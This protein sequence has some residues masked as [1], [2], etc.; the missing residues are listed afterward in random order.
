[1]MGQGEHLSNDKGPQASLLGTPSS[2][3]CERHP[4][5]LPS[6][7][8]CLYLPFFV[9]FFFFPYSVGYIY[10]FFNDKLPSFLTPSTSHAPLIP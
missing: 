1:M 5:V 4:P 9:F 10:L 3:P 2:R 8:R 6:D 7:F